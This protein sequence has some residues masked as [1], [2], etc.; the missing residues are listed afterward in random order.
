M[1]PQFE[2]K[3]ETFLHLQHPSKLVLHRMLAGQDVL[4]EKKSVLIIYALFQMICNFGKTCCHLTEHT[5]KSIFHILANILPLPY[6]I[7]ISVL[8]QGCIYFLGLERL[9]TMFG[10]WR[11]EGIPQKLWPYLVNLANEEFIGSKNNCLLCWP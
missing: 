3:Q 2:D 7:K 9:K 8:S 1:I 6:M 10:D 4:V 5:V 11:W